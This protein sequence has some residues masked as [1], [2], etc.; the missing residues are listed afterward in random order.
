MFTFFSYFLM[1]FCA[2]NKLFQYR[3]VERDFY[4]TFADR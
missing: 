3:L 1:S 2:R 4:R